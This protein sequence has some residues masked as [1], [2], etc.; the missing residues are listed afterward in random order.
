MGIGYRGFLIEGNNNNNN[1]NSN[2]NSNNIKY[3]TLY[4]RFK[5]NRSENTFIE[6]IK[7]LMETHNND[8]VVGNTRIRIES[9]VLYISHS[10]KEV[11]T[12]DQIDYN[13]YQLSIP[14]VDELKNTLPILRET[15]N[16]SYFYILNFS[17]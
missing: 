6:N 15:G 17:L 13:L 9:D 11:D 12:I 7:N 16:P 10:G 4:D 5:S 3:M 2:S 8:A 14:P 1:N